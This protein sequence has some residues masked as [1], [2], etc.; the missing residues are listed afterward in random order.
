VECAY[1]PADVDLGLAVELTSAETGTW[2][3]LWNRCLNWGDDVTQVC[4]EIGAAEMRA[5]AHQVALIPDNGEFLTGYLDELDGDFTGWTGVRTWRTADRDLRL[6][7]EFR[8][9]G[10][11]DV[12]WTV[13][14][15]RGSAGRWQASVVTTMEAGEQLRSLAT[16]MY[17][18]L[19]PG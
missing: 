14:P 18:F 7:A 9:R 15:W 19:Q 11:V 5:T 6:D 10:H 12:T 13:R 2:V 3:R 16:D 8:S 4:V 1:D 17:R